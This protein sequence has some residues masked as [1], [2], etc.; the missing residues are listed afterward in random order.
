M[1]NITVGAGEIVQLAIT[2]VLLP[3]WIGLSFFIPYALGKG[4]NRLLL[5]G[6]SFRNS[7]SFF[8]FAVGDWPIGCLVEWK[9]LFEDFGKVNP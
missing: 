5:S 7:S 4:I 2:L 3:L 8:A 9:T 6:R 1:G